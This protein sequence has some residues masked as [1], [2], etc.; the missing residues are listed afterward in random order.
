MRLEY[1]GAYEVCVPAVGAWAPGGV[2]E[3]ADM[4]LAEGLLARADF[5]E[6]RPE[7]TAQPVEAGE[8]APA[9]EVPA[10]SP[11][12]KRGPAAGG[13]QAAPVGGS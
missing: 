4:R 7:Q 2:K 13:G 1:T 6:A 5:R 11:A 3:I 9:E 12:R 8:T 10:Q